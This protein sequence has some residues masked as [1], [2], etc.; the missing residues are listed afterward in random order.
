LS[1]RRQLLT[2]IAIGIASNAALYLAYL[3][4]T[5]GGVGHKTAMT[6]L[7]AAGVSCTY[8]LNRNWTFGHTGEM[9]QSTRRYFG[10]YLLAYLGNMAALFLLVDIAQLPHRLVMLALIGATAAATFLLQKF[11]VFSEPPSQAT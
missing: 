11:W 7:F 3:A 10:V 9:R 5:A 4:L 2:F 6:A 8:L 1:S